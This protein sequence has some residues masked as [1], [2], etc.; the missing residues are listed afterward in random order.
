M[1]GSGREGGYSEPGYATVEGGWP[2]TFA[3]SRSVTMPVGD[4]PELLLTVA[5]KVT[6]WRS[7]DGFGAELRTVVVCPLF[8]VWLRGDDAAFACLPSPLYAALT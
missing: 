4:P 2:S 5:L 8:T 1:V 7:L 6:A 3:P